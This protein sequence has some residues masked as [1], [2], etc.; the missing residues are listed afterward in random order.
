MKEEISRSLPYLLKK[1]LQLDEELELKRDYI[2]GLWHFYSVYNLSLAIT[3]MEDKNI[4]RK[5]HL[6]RR[7]LS[8]YNKEGKIK[9]LNRLNR[10]RQ[11]EINVINMALKILELKKDEGGII[12]D[13]Y[14]FVGCVG[15]N[16]FYE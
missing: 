9:I 10:Y 15:I 7:L 13:N 8:N 6:F 16:A 3:G 12:G 11:E 5:N 2:R 1:R 4:N 14:K